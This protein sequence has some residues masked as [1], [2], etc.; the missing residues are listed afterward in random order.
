MWRTA[1]ETS[2]L[3]FVCVIFFKSNMEADLV[4]H[5]SSVIRHV[6]DFDL[7]E[8]SLKEDSSF[9]NSNTK[10]SDN[11]SDEFD[12]DI[13]SYLGR[14]LPETIPK[15]SPTIEEY[16]R[17]ICRQLR[18]IPCSPFIRKLTDD[19]IDISHYNVGPQGAK[20]IAK[21]LKRNT[22]T[23]LLNIS[24]NGLGVDGAIAVA[25]LLR[26]NFFITVLDV[27]TN[28]VGRD[29]IAAICEMLE[30]NRYLLEISL[31]ANKIGDESISC[32]ANALRENSTLR[33]L[34]V[35]SNDI[36][37]DGAAVLSCAVKNN[38]TLLH[39]NLSGNHIRKRGAI[40]L[41]EAVETNTSLRSVDLSFNG[42]DDHIADA[43]KSLL[44]KN[45]TLRELDISS[46]RLFQLSAR[47][48]AV[49]L[50][51][52]STLKVLKVGPNPM[53]SAGAKLIVDAILGYEFSAVEELYLDGIP[54][55]DEFEASLNDLLDQRSGIYVQY[56]TVV[57]GKEHRRRAKE[58]KVRILFLQI[59]VVNIM[60]CLCIIS[61]NCVLY[62]G[63]SLTT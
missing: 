62:I 6:T 11:S 17:C 50:E 26:E 5:D 4:D 49:G 52:N 35:S 29:G 46:N 44:K 25:D 3:L 23:S 55:T 39:L 32:I 21:T 40:K 30:S 43:L 51:K 37:G 60:F 48:I 36:S 34:D 42:L 61:R 1:T 53:Q 10:T 47:N 22:T 41:I 18:V 38:D 28:F 54:V 57:K 31:A 59:C 15:E 24:D 33:V 8:P 2:S 16:Y 58:Q 9:L 20:A 12:S 63:F 19:E 13:E 27:S 56:G 7:D 14:E 45:A